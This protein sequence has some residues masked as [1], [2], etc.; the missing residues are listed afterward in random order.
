M[1][2]GGVGGHISKGNF[3]NCSISSGS[4]M[5]SIYRYNILDM[6]KVLILGFKHRFGFKL[7]YGGQ[8]SSVVTVF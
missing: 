7:M 5:W 6:T 8:K 4:V 1:N 3:K 2:D